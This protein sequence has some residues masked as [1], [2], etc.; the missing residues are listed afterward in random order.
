MQQAKAQA[1]SALAVAY[2]MLVE[3]D[4]AEAAPQPYKPRFDKEFKAGLEEPATPAAAAALADLTRALMKSGVD[5]HGQKT[6]A[7]KVLAYVEKAANG[8]F[9]GIA[10]GGSLLRPGRSEIDR[11]RRGA[12]WSRPG[13]KFP[14]NPMFPYLL[15]LT[16]MTGDL[17]HVPA[18][19]GA[20]RCW[21]RR[22]GWRRRC[23][24]TPGGTSCCATSRTGSNA[25]A[26]ANPFAMG[27]MAD[28][29]GSCFDDWD[30]DDED[31]ED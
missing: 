13:E 3:Y 17:E 30:D 18:V 4:P 26:A 5:Y 21:R 2:L 29:F 6:H 24:R 28:I 19:S 7:K 9:H 23:R 8:R 16:Y 20:G 31:Y 11:G 22:G 1:P 10:N 25:L 27:F 12:S 14:A 15:A